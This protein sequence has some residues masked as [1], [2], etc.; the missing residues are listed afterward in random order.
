MSNASV[1]VHRPS[2]ATAYTPKSVRRAFGVTAAALVIAGGIT[3]CSSDDT[4]DDGPCAP[5][6]ASRTDGARPISLSTPEVKLVSPGTGPAQELAVVPA[7]TAP[8]KVTLTTSSLEAS[9]APTDRGSDA[10]QVQRTQQQLATPIT[11][12]TIC[13]DP[14]SLEF[15]IGSPTSKDLELSELLP[16]LDGST[17]GLSYTDGMVP[18]R[19]RLKPTDGSQSP[20]RSALEQSLLEALNYSVPLPTSPV[21]AGATWTSVRTVSAAAT[22]TQTMNVTLARRDGNVVTLDVKIDETPV[23]SIFSIPG[24]DDKLHISRF[25]MSGSGTLTVDLTKRFPVAGS[26]AV[27]GG[28]ELVGDDANRPIL[29]QN[30]FTLTWKATK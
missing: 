10:N 19:L 3:A 23:N 29:Q 6:A 9:I 4:A 26:L 24:S 20:A 11:A 12:R 2:S 21:G 28:R 14:S 25:S 17:G 18:T 5:T 13:D 15:S 8:Q 22:V 7:T 16:E 27:K 1:F 30:E